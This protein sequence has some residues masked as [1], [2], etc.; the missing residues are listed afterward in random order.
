MQKKEWMVSS[1]A[2]PERLDKVIAAYTDLSRR[3]ARSII[4][5]G[6]VY[7]NRKRV[8][9]LSFLV[10]P[11][12]GIQCYFDI[13]AHSNPIQFSS[14]WIHY[15]EPGFLILNKPAGLYS[16]PT[17]ASLKDCIL[18]QV[19]KALQLD[20]CVPINRLDKETSGLMVI[21]SDKRMAT[22]LSN[23]IQNRAIHKT[24]Q[25]IV[26]GDF[27]HDRLEINAPIGVMMGVTPTRYHVDHNQGRD[28]KTRI[29]R[30][31]VQNG[32]S[33]LEI[34]PVTGRTHQIRV[35][36]AHIGYPLVGDPI[37]GNTRSNRSDVRM[38]LHASHLKFMH[39]DTQ[40]PLQFYAESPFKLGSPN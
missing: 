11:G 13:T 6:G 21:A 32:C 24:Y 38:M 12:A 23:I 25:A 1:Q 40:I 27:P 39:P 26:E 22:A 9:K 16:Q 10:P 34:E 37:Y 30:L 19:E 15:H 17:R 8:R 14:T 4:A 29:K 35:H 33:H 7:V 5:E 28:A 2:D 18:F 31:V 36:L 3:Q 20:Y